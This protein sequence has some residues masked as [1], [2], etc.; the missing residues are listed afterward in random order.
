MAAPEIIMVLRHGEKPGD[1][2][3]PHGV[4]RHGE[5][6]D[7]GLTV[8]GWT[9]AGALA[10]LFALAPAASHPLL[11]TPGRIIATKPTSEARS[12]REIDTATPTAERLGIEVVDRHARGD[13]SEAAAEVLASPEPTLIVWHHGTLPRLVGH[14]PVMNAHDIPQAWPA[15]RFDLIWV[16]DL[17]PEPQAEYRF[18]VVP[19]LLLGG[20]SPVA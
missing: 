6:D 16:L 5:A 18:T 2:T 19:Q 20:D 9:R 8:R 17:Q 15:E 7:H 11:V 12:R 3:P 4:N 10:S 14:F 13:E 1:R